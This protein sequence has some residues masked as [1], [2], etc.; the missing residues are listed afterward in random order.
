MTF[1]NF[2]FNSYLASNKVQV[3]KYYKVNDTK[4]VS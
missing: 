1:I 3:I 2:L 4:Y